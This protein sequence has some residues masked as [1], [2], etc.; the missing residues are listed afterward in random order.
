[1]WD[2]MPLTADRVHG[3]AECHIACWREAHKD[4]VAA[5]VLD[6][7]DVE[8]SAAGWERIRAKAKA[9][10]IRIA[11]AHGQVI[12]FTSH[13]PARDRTAPTPL[14]LYTLYVRGGYYGTGLAD[15]LIESAVGST[16]PC[17]LW[18]FEQ[19]LRA[20][21]FYRRH[22][23]ALDGTIKPEPWSGGAMEARMARGAA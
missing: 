21:A 11:V 2:I 5:H 18:V 10:A 16:T 19:N 22:G 13:G 20:Q 8:R 3:L 4:I 23:F 15:A 17:T 9:G 14:Q 12:G 1:M 6:A 7:F